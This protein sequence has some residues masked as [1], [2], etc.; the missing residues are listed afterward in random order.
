MTDSSQAPAGLAQRLV[1]GVG[2]PSLT[3]AER[4]W[5]ERFRPAGVI[6]FARNVTGQ[7]QL[8]SLCQEL[9]YILG[10]RA[11]IVADHEGGPVSVLDAALGRPPAPFGLG[12]LDDPDL[13]RQV[14]HDTAR[15]LR[16]VGIRRVLAP[17]ADVLVEPHNSVIGS[18]A[19]GTEVDQVTDQVAAAVTGLR[20]GGVSCCLKH[21][22]GHGGTRSDSHVGPVRG[23]GGT[24]QK[25]F[26]AGVAAGADA[27]L[28]G[29]VPWPDSRSLADLPATLD[30]EAIAAARRLARG[31]S[32]LLFADDVTMGALRP[33]MT[34]L[35]PGSVSTA[36]GSLAAG[37][38]PWSRLPGEE[39]VADSAAG[40]L[41]PA[42]LSLSWLASLAAAGCDYLLCR[43]IPWAAFRVGVETRQGT[44]PPP[45][46]TPL[47]EE[48]Q[49]QAGTGS[50]RPEM[51]RS[52]R[53]EPASYQEARRRLVAGAGEPRRPRSLPNLSE[54]TLLWWDGT[55]GDRWG[56]AAPLA[57]VLGP[58]WRRW[59]RSGPQLPAPISPSPED[60]VQLNGYRIDSCDAILVTS[61]RP[62]D[63]APLQEVLTRVV[64]AAVGRGIT[65]GHPSLAAEV[66]KLLPATWSFSAV[67]DVGP[68]DLIAWLEVV[69]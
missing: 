48:T 8:R 34:Q 21:W 50:P 29:H 59:Q 69:A 2:G 68:A 64:P 51:T 56:E 67:Y 15:R 40:M 4:A 12:R 31:S 10:S 35:G 22:P 23:D 25:P 1:V 66:S 42:K 24:L 19:F 36:G 7:E 28:V 20:E 17:C 38:A 46:G 37:A 60:V 57:T 9:R 55:C 58:R 14:H 26:A 47:A 13:T 44:S 52:P 3:A 45:A 33:V 32:L 49:R 5:L 30:P 54:G 65:M 43:G 63:L 39:E 18:R 62:L 11:E 61:H 41:D 16:A 53:I 6:L 27:L